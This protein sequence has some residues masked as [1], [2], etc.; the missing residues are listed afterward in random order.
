MI[1]LEDDCNNIR[2]DIYRCLECI[3]KVED[4]ED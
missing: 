2:H 1:C 4:E 3:D